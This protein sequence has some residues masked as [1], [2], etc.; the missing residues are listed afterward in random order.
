[1]RPVTRFVLLTFTAC[2]ALHAQAPAQPPG[3]TWALV[4]GVAKFQ[5]LPSELWLQ[6]PE[7]DAKS[8]AEFVQSPRGGGRHPGPLAPHHQ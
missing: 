7:V 6:Y 2:L 4:V 5:K 8:F 1:M 3:K